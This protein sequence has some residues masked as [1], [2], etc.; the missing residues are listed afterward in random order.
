MTKK[1]NSVVFL[2]FLVILVLVE[3]LLVAGKAAVVN[4]T[5]KIYVPVRI[6]Q[7]TSS[8]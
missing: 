4:V 8:A 5:K 6:S 1:V 2:V 3:V 7:T